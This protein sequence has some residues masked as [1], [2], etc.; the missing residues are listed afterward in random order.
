M[1]S[2]VAVPGY[3]VADLRLHDGTIF[4]VKQ[5][6]ALL[7]MVNTSIKDLAT[8]TRVPDGNLDVLQEGRT[9]VVRS[10][11]SNQIQSFDPAT[12]RMG[13]VVSVTWRSTPARSP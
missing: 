4:A 6:R 11:S 3:S 9:I 1:V 2:A 12:G 7:G 13:S 8:A 5:D 10:R